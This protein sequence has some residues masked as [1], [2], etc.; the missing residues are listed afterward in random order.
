MS[1]K[2]LMFFFS[3]FPLL[4]VIAACAGV[5]ENT[6]TEVPVTGEAEA[7]EPENTTEEADP[8]PR[9]E[10]AEPLTENTE[11]EEP[12]EEESPP[13]I[14]VP[15]DDPLPEKPIAVVSL[16]PHKPAGPQEQ[17]AGGVL[18]K[19]DVLHLPE[20]D[21]PDI[22]V[23]GDSPH[24]GSA[25]QLRRGNPFSHGSVIAAVMSR[26][27][28]EARSAVRS[29]MAYI[30]GASG[31]NSLKET[32]LVSPESDLRNENSRL[33]RE[34]V[35][36][37]NDLDEL[38]IIVESLTSEV[39]EK[40]R[41]IT[42]LRS[43]AEEQQ[44]AIAR[45]EN[46]LAEKQT[47]D[48]S[49]TPQTASAETAA[50]RGERRGGPGEKHIYAVP[51]DVIAVSMSGTGWIYLGEESGKQG[52]T[53]KARKNNSTSTDFVFESREPGEFVLLFQRQDNVRG[54]AE[55]QT[56]RVS[57]VEEA[58]FE[59]LLSAA[60]NSDT[61]AA[62]LTGRPKGYLLADAYYREGR[63]EE[64]LAEY[65]KNYAEGDPRVNHRIAALSFNTGNYEQAGLYW[66]KNIDAEGSYGE[67]ALEGLVRSAVKREDSA[68]LDKLQQRLLDIENIP[69]AD[70]LI[71]AAR[72]RYSRGHLK[73]AAELLK[74]LLLRYP[75]NERTD[76]TNYTLGA[77][78]ESPGQFRDLQKAK[79]YYRVVMQDFP[80]SSY[81]EKAEERIKYI[82]RN[83]LN[84]R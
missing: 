45:L 12:L 21:F 48:L 65:L 2:R 54:E 68:A 29:I 49:G 78:Y 9:G 83:F 56:I 37:Q 52:I 61:P 72:F 26:S 64:S 82:D 40:E 73:S 39:R 17:H 69:I 10:K 62:S 74:A 18:R 31:R 41:R 7:E 70:T 19:E 80:S 16:F 27:L 67:L 8:V 75:D 46:S 13:E 38:R 81:W 51:K 15:G 30:T 84:I 71:E 53:F 35:V 44:A 1:L 76:W 28:E 34:A 23:D 24:A 50:D 58:R 36:L 42:A 33:A 43:K 63:K 5:P 77:I 55:E 20:T 14:K 22:P 6:R 32:V 4:V 57:V 59:E 66:R 3:T 25:E 11:S 60:G 47:P 79:Y